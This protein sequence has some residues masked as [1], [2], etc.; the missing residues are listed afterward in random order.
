MDDRERSII[1]LMRRQGLRAVEIAR[2]ELGE[3]EIEKQAMIVTAKGGH[4][5]VLPVVDE[6]MS[7]IRTYVATR[8][9]FAGHLLESYQ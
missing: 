3:I 5:R 7:A 1:L 4:E 9:S 2:L 6:V 8:G